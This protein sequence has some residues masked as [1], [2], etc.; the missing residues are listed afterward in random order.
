M[1]VKK[2][3]GTIK[4]GN[5]IER[6]QVGKAVPKVVLDFWKKTKQL[7]ALKKSGAIGDSEEKKETVKKANE[8]IRSFEE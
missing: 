3:I 4:I 7:D 2:P 5:T 6:L 1:I 8:P